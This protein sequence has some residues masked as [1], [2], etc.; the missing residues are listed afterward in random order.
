MI[1]KKKEVLYTPLKYFFTP[2]LLSKPQNILFAPHFNIL[3]SQRTL[4]TP[5]IQ[6]LLTPHSPKTHP[7]QIR[8]PPNNNKSGDSTQDQKYQV[9][10]LLYLICCVYSCIFIVKYGFIVEFF[11]EILSGFLCFRILCSRILKSEFELPF[12]ISLNP[13][14]SSFFGFYDVRKY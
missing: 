14:E 5:R 3:L 4:L 8:E 2:H 13:V 10:L 6:S 9:S 12:R 7:P 11:F 1:L